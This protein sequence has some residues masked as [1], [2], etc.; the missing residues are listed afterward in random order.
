MP[1]RKAI[2]IQPRRDGRFLGRGTSQ[3]YTLM[4]LASLV[5]SEVPVE[6]WDEDLMT[7]PIETLGPQDLIGISAKTLLIDRAKLLA[8][9]IRRQGAAVVIGGTHATLVP[10]EVAQWAD[11]IAVGEGYRTWPQIIRDFDNGTLQRRYVDEEWAPLD[12]GI[13]ML[14]DRV[15]RAMNEHR[16]YWTPYLEITRGCP[17]SCTF[18]TAIRV[19]GRVMRLRPVEE[20]VEEI[21]RRR[22]WRFFL[23]DDNFGLN[24]RLHPEYMEALFRALAKLPLKSWTCQ[25][26]Q[27]VADYPDLLNLARE[28]HLDKFF[29]GFESVNSGNRKELGG[30][31]RGE[32]GRY[33][34]VIRRLHAHGI[35]AVGLFVFGFD[36]DTV[37]TFGAA[38][39]FIRSSE[40]D[41]ASATILTPYPGTAQR[42]E[43][44]AARRI[45]PHDCPSGDGLCWEKYD[46]N[47][48]TYLPARMTV[49]E[50]A[51]GYDWLCR[52]LYHPIHIARRGLRAW[53]SHS[54]S[55]AGAR[56]VSSFSTDIGYRRE[57]SHRHRG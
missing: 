45:I 46:T 9:R 13:A 56:F 28:A 53:S 42:Q 27:M 39:D 22:L 31:A 43:L 21:E 16:N 41:S 11:A 12:S 26:E 17:R 25:A 4:R 2:L 36:S 14:Q 20:V 5:P 24:F 52:Q 30:K 6:I 3:P 51:A 50:L 48:V 40:L 38:W 23:T 10:D 55:K 7:L 47:H 54:W 33:R 15:L 44:Q 18:C 35:G 29:I 49:S 32:V 37:D 8:R 19:S 57:F 1:I 34:E